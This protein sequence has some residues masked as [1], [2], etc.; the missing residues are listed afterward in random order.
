MSASRSV[1]ETVQDTRQRLLEAAGEVFAAHGFHGATVRQ[2]T[3]RAGVNLAAVNY[4]FRDKA[5]LYAAAVREC[6]CTAE[7]GERI[8]PSLP[9]KERLRLFIER[10]VREKVGADRPEWHHV[11]MTREMVNPT[12]SL[13][14]LVDDR[15]CPQARELTDIIREL[16][17]PSTPEDEIQMMGF[18]VA[19]QALFHLRHR[20]LAARVYPPFASRPLSLEQIATHIYRFSLAAIL[21]YGEIRRPA[22][23]RT[24]SKP[25]PVP[26]STTRA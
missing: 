10:F 1:D 9:P 24:H 11:L 15:V 21:H 6:F 19:S 25:A 14:E 16:R 13:Q 26:K 18:S 5:E 20:L 12:P 2:I 22:P 3:D 17:G 4:H 7:T 23:R 8:D